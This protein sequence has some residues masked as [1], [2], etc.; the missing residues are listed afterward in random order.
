MKKYCFDTSGISNPLETMPEDIHKTMWAGFC[1]RV[2]SGSIATTTEIHS[3][4]CYIPGD[5]G[6]RLISSKSLLVLEVGEEWDWQ[7]YVDHAQRMQVDHKDFISE[8]TGGSAKTI[9]LND[10]TIIALAKTLSL[11]LVSMERLV[12]EDPG[13]KKRRIPNICKAEGVEHLVFNDFL[14]RENL[15]F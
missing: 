1:E 3:E 13:T 5:V 8:F 14:R 6:K 2:E 11:P 15:T 12:P 10:L 9:C 4:F 7:T